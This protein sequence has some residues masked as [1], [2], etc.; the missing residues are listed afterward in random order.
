[1][2]GSPFNIDLMEDQSYLFDEGE[3]SLNGKNHEC[4]CTSM[5]AVHITHIIAGSDF[6]HLT[7]LMVIQ[8]VEKSLFRDAYYFINFILISFQDAKLQE[9]LIRSKTGS[10]G[11]I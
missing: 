2:S 3:C 7:L 11:T 4:Y 10:G 5:N 6:F 8:C 1:M 9:R